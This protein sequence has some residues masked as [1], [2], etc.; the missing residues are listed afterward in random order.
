[1]LKS[2][3]AVIMVH[4]LM[5]DVSTSPMIGPAAYKAT[6]VSNG[7]YTC[8]ESLFWIS[9]GATRTIPLRTA[10]IKDNIQ[11]M[12]SAPA[13][14]PDSVHSIVP[15]KSWQ[16]WDHMG[17]LDA[18]NPEEDRVA[19]CM[20]MRNAIAAKKMAAVI[21]EWKVHATSVAF[22]FQIMMVW[23]HGVSFVFV[24]VRQGGS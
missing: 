8:P 2:C 9:D 23:T 1:M 5:T 6:L 4:H 7:T 22:V 17:S 15:N 10:G 18:G 20:G 14:Y 3:R 13:R 16:P 24:F 19:C 21:K 11:Q 12:Y